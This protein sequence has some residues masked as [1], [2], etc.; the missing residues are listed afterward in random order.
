MNRF[1]A[2]AF[3]VLSTSVLCAQ[4]RKDRIQNIQTFDEHKYTWGYYLGFNNND[5]KIDL[6]NNGQDILVDTEVGFN[7][8]LVGD[9]RINSFLNLRFEPGL[10]FTRR[11]LNF[12]GFAPDSPDATRDVQST[13]VHFPLLLKVSAKRLNNF[14]PFLVG[15][16]STSINLASDEDSKDDNTAGVFRLKTNTYYYELGFGIDFYTEYFKFTPSIRGIFALNDELVRDND[17][18]SP[19]TGNIESLK[20][21]GI[22]IN[23]TFQ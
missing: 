6:K 12:P 14:K 18:N 5:F 9:M 3:F 15:G 2:F 13:Y 8:G 10:H 7:V 17:P 22:F 19:W 16:L 1:L 21:R 23:L 20:S 11:V 4:F